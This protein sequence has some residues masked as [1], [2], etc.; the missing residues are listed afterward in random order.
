MRNDTI[1]TIKGI[2]G[3]VPALKTTEG[4]TWTRFRLACAHSYQR[5][6]G[7]WINED[8]TWYTIR[9]NGSL[10]HK[11]ATVVRKGTP[12]I[13][14]GN[15]RWESWTDTEGRDQHGPALKADAIGLDMDGRGVLIY[16]PP[17]R[18]QPGPDVEDAAREVGFES[19]GLPPVTASDAVPAAVGTGTGESD[20]STDDGE[21]PPF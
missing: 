5:P 4:R 8:S 10:A 1:I 15:L 17:A 20:A 11:V 7:V 2:A 16:E 3:T 12:L 6:D 19:M 9:A 21:G 14:R 13:V 18:N